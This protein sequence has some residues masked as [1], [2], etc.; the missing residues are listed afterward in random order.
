[1]ST[2]LANKQTKNHRTVLTGIEQLP[3]SIYLDPVVVVIDVIVFLVVNCNL[4]QSDNN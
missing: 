4:L 3:N 2:S 1:M